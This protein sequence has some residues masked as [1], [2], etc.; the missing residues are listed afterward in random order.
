MI[1]VFNEDKKS[2]GAIYEKLTDKN[3][4]KSKGIYYTPDYIVDYILKYTVSESDIV[5]NPFIK[6]LDPTCG[7]GYFL[8]KSYDI[9]REKFISS[10]GVLQKKYG[11]HIYYMEKKSTCADMQE[12]KGTEYWR[13]ENIDYHI[14]KNC[15]YG[16]DLDPVAV[17]LAKRNLLSRCQSKVEVDMNIVQGDSLIRW[18]KVNSN[19]E[20]DIV[21][22]IIYK[23]YKSHDRREEYLATNEIDRTI[24]NLRKFW[25]N[26]FDYIIGNPPYIVLLQSQIEKDYWNYI[27]NNYKTIGYKK[28]MFYLL[29]E[30]V[31]DVLKHGGRHSFIIPDRYFLTNSYEESRKSL[32]RNSKII[33]ITRFS[34]KVFEDAIVG[35]VVYIVEKGSCEKSY[36]IPIKLDYI[37]DNNFYSSSINQKD[38]SKN[39]KFTVNIL[40]KYE[41]QGLIKKIK[42]NS[43]T[44]RDFSG[45]H[46]GMMIKDK[47]HHFENHPYDNK[48][49]RV[50]VGRDLDKYI[51]GNENR[52]FNA[53]DVKIF[54]G[55]KSIEKHKNC[56][57]ILLRKT[58][59][60]IVAAID[61]CGIFAE[62]SVYLIIPYENYNVFNLL[63]QIQSELCN[64]YFKEALITNPKAYPYIQHYDAERLPIN[65]NLM[66]DRQYRELIKKIISVK[67]E[68][69]NLKF[70]SIIENKDC[71]KIIYHYDQFK[72]H[73]LDFKQK[74]K[75]SI[76]ESNRILYEAYKFTKKDVILIENKLSGKNRDS[77]SILQCNK[78]FE[79]DK[80]SYTYY[81]ELL[82]ELFN[83]LKSE[84]IELLKENKRYLSVEEIEKG[85]KNRIKNFYEIITII[86]NYKYKK[87]NSCII[88]KMLNSYS[89]TW[90]KYMRSRKVTINKKDLVKYNSYEYGLASWPEDIHKMWFKDNR[91]TP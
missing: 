17:Q 35:T 37:D 3:T 76:T 51:I 14:I 46:V 64:F 65:L 40:T 48:R 36:S 78:G 83:V 71:H 82:D 86:K 15:L 38:I 56:P 18:E 4:R 26:K 68:I 57:K 44:L 19:D 61:E 67:N 16:M 89:D 13:E 9:L 74:L 58:G 85:L 70:N 21:K 29:M 11:N 62:Q 63:G 24:S 81:N 12:V 2:I 91:K 6:I 8:A 49:D 39:N 27:I 69:K 47:N 52:H 53:N 30:R 31:I 43:K 34:N 87:D 72:E 41:Y 45:V 28:N 77:S 60:N 5:I 25:S 84:T 33:N 50:V 54:G 75:D 88:K 23:N 1:R 42:D 79:L 7:V 55:T 73:Q 90:N 80:D 22:S 59:D 10:L 20:V 32:F 66:Y